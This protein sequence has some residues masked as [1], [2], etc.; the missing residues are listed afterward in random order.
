M[1]RSVPV[2]SFFNH[3]NI[4]YGVIS[5]LCTTSTCPIMIGP[6][7]S[8]YYWIDERGKK[9]KYSAPQYIELAIIFIQKS[10]SNETIFPT[11]LDNKF[12]S[13]FSILIRKMVRLLFHCLAHIYAVHY[14]QLIEFEL[15]PHLNS[16]FLHLISF[17]I[18]SDIIPSDCSTVNTNSNSLTI[19]SQIEIREFRTELES[20]SLLYQLLA[21]QWQHAY[22]QESAQKRKTSNNQ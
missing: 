11:R 9:V 20:L 8:L 4:L 10:L 1:P 22:A 12:P 7:N 18:K 6:Q 21:K 19:S 13:T 5:H 15:H 17:L 14:N 16:L 3:I 2:V